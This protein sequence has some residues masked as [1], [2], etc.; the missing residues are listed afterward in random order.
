MNKI[1]LSSINLWCTKNLVDTQFL[2]WKIFDEQAQNINYFPD[3]YEKQ[4]EYVILNTCGF[5]SSGRDEMMENIEKLIKKN[6]KI[7]LIW[8]GMIY[9]KALDPQNAPEILNNPNIIFAS[10]KDLNKTFDEILKNKNTISIQYEFPNAPRAYTNIDY[11]FEYLKIAEWCNNSCSFCIIP[12]IRW[13]QKSLE[14]EK[15]VDETKQMINMGI[16]EIILIAQDTTRYWTDLYGKPSL[17]EL[18][19]KIDKLPWDFMYRVLYLYPDIITLKQLEKLTKLEKFIPYFDIPLQHISSN[20][21]KRMKRFYDE[22]YIIK[23]LDFINQNF[24]TKFVRTNII[25]WFPWETKEDFDKLLEFIKTYNFDNISLFE[26]HDEPLAESSKLDHKVSYDIIHKR[27]LEI[28][29]LIDKKQKKSNKW[30]ELVWFVMEIDEKWNLLV[31]NW[32]H[33]PEID[34]Y[35]KITIKNIVWVY[36]ESWNIDIWDKIIYKL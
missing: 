36:N 23:F 3:P 25:I 12:N 28:K 9:F 33:A 10:W 2:L 6:K 20:I 11:G 7:I 27:F 4:V 13:K 19:E 30:I 26:Y 17:F 24:K 22:N 18:L 15:I 29:S 14:I 5:I 32:L 31:R 8:C 16:K 35:D 21:L 34:S 1:N